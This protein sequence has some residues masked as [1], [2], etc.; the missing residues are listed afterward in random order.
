LPYG[1]TQQP[2]PLIEII[3]TADPAVLNAAWPVS[4]GMTE[5]DRPGRRQGTLRST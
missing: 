5:E 1:P 4:V 3:R 2:R